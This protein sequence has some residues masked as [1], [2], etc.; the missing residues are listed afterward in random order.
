MF[1]PAKTPEAVVSRLNQEVAKV[2]NRPEVK[3]RLIASGSEVIA[4]SPAELTAAV[5]ADL[6]R[7]GKVIK[8]AGIREE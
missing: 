6:A 3:E 4:S 1:A 5:K 7:M 2:L 8:D